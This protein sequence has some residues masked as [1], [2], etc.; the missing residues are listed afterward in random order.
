MTTKN[1]KIKS[2]KRFL[3]SGFIVKITCGHT[4]MH[5]WLHNGYIMFRCFGQS[6]VK[7]TIKDL[8]WL[9]NN[10]LDSKRKSIDYVLTT[11][12]YN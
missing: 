12:I 10:I 4:D 2:V 11:S 9:V 6:A 8:T 3:D 5:V 7:N 1:E